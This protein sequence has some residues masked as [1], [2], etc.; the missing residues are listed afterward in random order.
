[1][2][3]KYG[4]KLKKSS[5]RMIIH[6]GQT[7]SSCL[8]NIPY[9]EI[10]SLLLLPYVG[11]YCKEAEEFLGRRVIDSNVESQ[12]TDLRNSIKIFCEKYNKSEKQ[13]I[14]TDDKQDEYFKD[15]LR[16]DFTRDMDIH[17][18][19]G[20]YF[21]GDGHVIGNTQL[22]NFHLNSASL[23][24]MNEKQNAYDMG[25]SIG[26]SVTRILML[27]KQKPRKKVL[28]NIADFSIGYIDCNSNTVNAPFMY[29]DNKGLNLLLLHMLGLFGTCKYVIRNILD[30]K[31]T[32]VYRCEYVIYHNIWNGLRIIQA[33]F[34]QSKSSVTDPQ[35]LSKLV[36]DGRVFFPSLYRN[37]MMH[38]GLISG[39]EACIKE[40]YYRPD[41]PLYG[42]V[43]SCFYGKTAE[44][45][46]KDLRR[47][48]DEVEEFLNGWFSFDSSRIRWDL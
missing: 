44:D 45:Y 4:E 43:E 8:L 10:V 28:D 18:N 12:I 39:D 21:D 41:I 16:F 37:C 33:H 6:D 36:E 15:L 47:Y 17:Y 25:Y 14:L 38:Y 40:E 2:N 35:S 26:V 48:M 23:D 42:L 20:I 30:D 11:L 24:G 7:I 3:R 9:K 27:L 46:Y 5:E 13:F 19:L 1:M 34:E 22:I 32:W 31:N 29:Q